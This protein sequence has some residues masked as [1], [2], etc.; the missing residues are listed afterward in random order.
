[1]AQTYEATPEVD[2]E[3]PAPS[4]HPHNAAETRT[5]EIRQGSTGF[6]VRYI[7]AFSLGLAVATLGLLTIGAIW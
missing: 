2:T 5:E 3:T 6:G 1:M 4:T 7:L